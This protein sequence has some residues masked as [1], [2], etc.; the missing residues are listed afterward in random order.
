MCG[1]VGFYRPA[2]EPRAAKDQ[3]RAM[4]DTIVHRG[5]DDQGVFTDGNG[6]VGLGMCRLSIIDVTGHQ[7][8]ENED[9]TIR[10]VFKW[11][12]L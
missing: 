2:F 7:P 11:R 4:C 9:G 6:T 10:V 3:L 8:I 1:I 5:P 12:N